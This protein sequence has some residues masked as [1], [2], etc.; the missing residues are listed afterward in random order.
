MHSKHVLP[1]DEYEQTLQNARDNN[2]DM[3]V[4]ENMYARANDI[5]GTVVTLTLH[6]GDTFGEV[7]AVDFDADTITIEELFTG[8]EYKRSTDRAL[9]QPFPGQEFTVSWLEARIDGAWERVTD[10]SPRHEWRGPTLS[11]TESYDEVR[12]ITKTYEHAA[13]EL[14][15]FDIRVDRS[16]NQPEV[17][18]DEDDVI[19]SDVIEKLLHA[20]TVPDTDRLSGSVL[21]TIYTKERFIEQNDDTVRKY[22]IVW[23][24]T[25]RQFI[26]NHHQRPSPVRELDSLS[27]ADISWS[28]A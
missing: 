25:N 13:A 3:T 23:W 15:A 9:D 14:D 6:W 4:I 12:E 27:L 17:H 1:D 22:E 18:L 7:T 10:K 2:R 20:F 16:T 26:A 28:Y 5:I 11:D 21:G 8:E 24:D 19:N